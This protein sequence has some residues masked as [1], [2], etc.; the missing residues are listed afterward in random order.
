MIS[1][2]GE[3]LSQQA[4]HNAVLA[5][6]ECLANEMNARSKAQQPFTKEELRGLQQSLWNLGK[7]FDEAKFTDFWSSVAHIPH[8]NDWD[9]TLK[10]AERLKAFLN[11]G[12]DLTSEKWLQRVLEDGHWETASS[13]ETPFVVLV[14]G[15]NGI[16]KSTALYQPWFLHVLREALGSGVDGNFSEN[17]PTGRNSF[18]RQLDYVMATACNEEFSRLYKFAK[19]MEA[20]VVSE[21]TSLL[22]YSD[23][24]AA[25]FSRYR[26][27]AELLGIVLLQIAQN[28]S[29]NC[30]METSG[31]NEAM[32][33]YIDRLYQNTKYQKLALHFVVN[34]IEAAQKTVDR[35]M[36]QEMMTGQCARVPEEVVRVNQGGPYGSDV[37]PDVQFESENVWKQVET[38]AIA[39]DWLKATIY[40]DANDKEPWTARALRPDGTHG[41]VYAYE[42]LHCT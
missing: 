11:L 27:V 32:F 16:R 1:D 41:K 14:T 4:E 35:R 24:K 19:S 33:A 25:I 34:D 18:F 7:S 2:D 9:A 42:P 31:R 38:G 28:E 12:A 23:F 13:M 30:I 40:I 6:M 15:L 3:G 5:E 39:T 29:K 17:K 37:L 20:M 10:N 8:T 21:E 26:T 36:R 22:R